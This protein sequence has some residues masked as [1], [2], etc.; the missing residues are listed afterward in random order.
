MYRSS[1]GGDRLVNKERCPACAKKGK[2][3]SE[4]N[5]GR[6]EDGHAWCYS[7]GYRE[8]SNVEELLRKAVERRD[9]IA[10]VAAKVKSPLINSKITLPSDSTKT[11]DSQAL[12]WLDKYGIIRDEIIDNEI[13]WSPF[14]KWLIFPIRGTGDVL[15]GYQARNFHQNDQRKWFTQGDL[16]AVTHILGEEKHIDS[17]DVVLVEDL[18]S[19]IRVARYA[20]AM[21]LFGAYINV[22]RL[23]RLRHITNSAIIWLDAN[24]FVESIAYANRCQMIGMKA[25]AV[26]TEVDPKDCTDK[27]IQEV[28]RGTRTS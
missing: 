26:F 24:K 5:L 16:G 4:D 21:P 14:N 7:C 13:Q 6:Y 19:A 15:L 28:I 11:I 10:Q 25:R 22:L 1:E 2:D 8:G 27:R 9:D 18:V 23:E 12:C 3:R 20:K 17:S